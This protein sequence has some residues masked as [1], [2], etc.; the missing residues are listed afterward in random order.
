MTATMV[1]ESDRKWRCL[2]VLALI[3]QHDRHVVHARQQTSPAL[4]I[5]AKRLVTHDSSSIMFRCLHGAAYTIP[6]VSPAY[7]GTLPS[8]WLELT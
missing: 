2:L 4:Q 5:P 6:P 3:P 8:Q 7:V 1:L